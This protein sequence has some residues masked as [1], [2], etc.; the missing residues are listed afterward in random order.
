MKRASDKKAAPA[1]EPKGLATEPRALKDIRVFG[2]D[3]NNYAVV[4]V[5]DPQEYTTKDAAL[6]LELEQFKGTDH[7]LRITA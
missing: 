1:P 7:P 3:K 2:K 6:A 5:G 4:L